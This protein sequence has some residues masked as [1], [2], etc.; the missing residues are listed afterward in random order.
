M[1]DPKAATPKAKAAATTEQ[2]D[3]VAG[4]IATAVAS[5][6]PA[7]KKRDAAQLAPI[8]LQEADFGRTVFVCTAM[9]GTLP[10]DL[11]HQAYWAHVAP[12]LKPWARIEVRAD[13]ASWYAE[14]LVLEAGR[15]WANVK[16]LHCW[17]LSGEDI[18][19]TSAAIA[20]E[21][22]GL[23][24]EVKFRGEHCLWSVLRKADAAVMHE[25]EATKAGA[26]QWLRERMKADRT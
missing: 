11:A 17:N 4:P 24:Y 8:R 16:T 12:S 5:A 15:N 19:R 13:D 21:Y 3:N 9:P 26:D 2:A 6:A 7:E 1:A 20:A 10:E 18:A 25:G 23:P 22:A 14:C